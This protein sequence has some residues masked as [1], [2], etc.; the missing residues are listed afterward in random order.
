[1]TTKRIKL[2]ASQEAEALR[3]TGEY[4]ELAAQAVGQILPMIPVRFD[5]RGSSAGQY[6]RRGRVREI[7][8]N[9]YIFARYFADNLANT[10][11]HEVAHYA[12]D[13]VFGMQHVRPH[14][15]EWRTMMQA[16][17]AEPEVR[18]RYDLSGLPTGRQRRF[19]Y[20]CGC[21]V[22]QFTTRRHNMVQ[23]DR[24]HYLCRRCGELLIFTP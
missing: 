20:R 19:D 13:V 5:L 22:H 8:Y 7:R 18:A 12:V 15:Q 14:G 11:P 4:I 2:N 3:L 10:V 24:Q 9:S 16:L 1:M 6:R 23:R 17:G 21:A